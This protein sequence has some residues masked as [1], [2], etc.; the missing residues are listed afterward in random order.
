MY[1]KKIEMTDEEVNYFARQYG[2]TESIIDEFGK[3][4]PNPITA[5]EV[6]DKKI[7]A[8]LNDT[9]FAFKKELYEKTKEEEIEVLKPNIKLQKA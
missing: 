2:W 5:E 8:Y 9:I 7:E 3:E 6:T 1:K 4:I